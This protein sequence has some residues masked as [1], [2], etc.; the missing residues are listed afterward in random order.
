VARLKAQGLVS[1]YL[2]TFV[3]ARVNPLRFIKGE[4]PDLDQLLSTMTRRA[5]SLKTE[6][7]KPGDLARAGGPSGEE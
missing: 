5:R 3:V 4:L 6:G 1:P 7:V 2:K